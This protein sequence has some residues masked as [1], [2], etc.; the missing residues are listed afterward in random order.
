MTK[1]NPSVR[2]G[3][4]NLLIA[5][6]GLVAFSAVAACATA[7]ICGFVLDSFQDTNAMVMLITDAG[8]KSDDKNLE[9]NL[10]SATLALKACRDLGLALAVGCAGCGL[11]VG[12]RLWK[13]KDV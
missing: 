11:A 1:Q 3:D 13:Q 7:Y 4:R 9:K 5:I 6:V 12:L 10:S 8:T 2:S